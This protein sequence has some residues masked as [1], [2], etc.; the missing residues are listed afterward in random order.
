MSKIKYLSK[1]DFKIAQTCATKLFYKK[2]NYPNTNQ[3]N[4]FN[5]YL[6]STKVINYIAIV[7]HDLMVLAI[8]PQAIVSNKNP[9]IIL[10]S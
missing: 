8:K 2:K 7:F 10:V 9:H 5:Y 1:S 6:I 3:E 4:E